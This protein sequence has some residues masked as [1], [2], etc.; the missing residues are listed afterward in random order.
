M[1]DDLYKVLGVERDATQEEI[2][3]EYRSLAKEHH[4]DKGGDTS[5]FQDIALA[6]EILSNDDTRQR[7]DNGENVFDTADPERFVKERVTQVFKE[8]LMMCDTK[9]DDIFELVRE[10]IEALTRHFKKGIE[11][12]RLDIKELKDVIERISGEGSEFFIGVLE[13]DISLFENSIKQNEQEIEYVNKAL[14]LIKDIEYRTDEKEEHPHY[15]M[16]G[17][18]ERVTA[19]D[20]LKASGRL[21]KDGL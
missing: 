13:Q 1:K 7:Y 2:K 8:K 11:K 6:Y 10:R 12:A 18:A 19:S 16:Y 5:K 17:R 21:F 3:K 9:H 4:P 15:Q 14:E 20:I